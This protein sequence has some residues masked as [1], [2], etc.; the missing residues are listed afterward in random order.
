MDRVWSQPRDWEELS[1]NQ[2]CIR[3]AKSSSGIHILLIIIIMSCGW[4]GFGACTFN[5]VNAECIINSEN[6]SSREHI[7]LISQRLFL[8]LVAVFSFTD[9]MH[10]TIDDR[11]T[12][13]GSSL[14][15]NISANFLPLFLSLCVLFSKIRNIA[16]LLLLLLPHDIDDDVEDIHTV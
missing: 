16:F 13:D 5:W 6:S 11:P 14:P 3:S 7:W 10:F 8:V 9:A 2:V 15:T 1:Y 4:Y 12:D